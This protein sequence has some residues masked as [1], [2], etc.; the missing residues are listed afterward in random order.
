MQ[1]YDISHLPPAVHDAVLHLMATLVQAFPPAAEETTDTTPSTGPHRTPLPRGEGPVP[2]Q[3]A[4]VQTR[5]VPTT[6]RCPHGTQDTPCCA[7]CATVY[8]AEAVLTDVQGAPPRFPRRTVELQVLEALAAL[9]PMPATSIQVAAM[10]NKPP[11]EVRIILQA[12]AM[13]ETVAHPRRG[14]YRYRPP[15]DGAPA[16]A[17]F[18]AQIAAVCVPRTPQGPTTPPTVGGGVPPPH[19]KA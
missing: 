11:L 5:P 13:L 7:A 18:A 8:T 1:S 6:P 10:I 12:L 14:Y 4:G 19:T 9:A 3:P 2:P 16:S 17:R 15:E